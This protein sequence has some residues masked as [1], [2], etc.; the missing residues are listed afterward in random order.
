MAQRTVLLDGG[1]ATELE[2]RGHDLSSALWSARLLHDDPAAIVEA[3]RAFVTAGAE[4]V[5]SGSYQASFEALGPDAETLLRRS[6]ALAREAAPQWVAASVGPYGAVR[7]DGSEYRGDYGLSVAELRKWHRRRLHVL[8][9]AGPDVLAVE[10]IPCL[11]E[12]EALCAE[13]A[14]LGFPAW[15]SISCAGPAT[16]AGE[17]AARAFAMAGDCAAVI[18]TGVNCT[19]PADVASL[20]R[21]AAEVSGKPV[22]A[23]PNSGEDWDAE[24]R[25]W[26]GARGF[27]SA[28]V[29]SWREAGARLIG[30][31]CRVR[32]EDIRDLD[33]VVQL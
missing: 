15:L 29:A 2:R 13:L 7:A 18:A 16:R 8:A 12:V 28:S 10:T 25:H 9:D 19:A 4:V 32:P 5:T 17:P 22:V 24:R 33:A 21:T 30:G 3:H 31:C 11:A 14:E 6:V 20:V 1:L 23:Y 26:V 27:S